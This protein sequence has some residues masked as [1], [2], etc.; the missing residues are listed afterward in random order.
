MAIERYIEGAAFMPERI[1]VM[2]QAFEG[3]LKALHIGP[4]EVSK[5]E[6]AAQMIV[7]LAQADSSLNATSLRDYAI[8]ALQ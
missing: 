7:R 1:S 8:E 6:A 5:K 3:V 4:S 2:G